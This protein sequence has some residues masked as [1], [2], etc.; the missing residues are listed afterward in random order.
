MVLAVWGWLKAAAT[1]IPTRTGAFP[2]ALAGALEAGRAGAAT[3]RFAPW[4]PAPMSVGI[5][6]VV[7]L[8][9]LVV[10]GCTAIVVVGAGHAAC[11]T[12]GTVGVACGGAID[13]QLSALETS[14]AWV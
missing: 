2:T 6:W 13:R 4:G 9:V 12:C 11:V 1:G 3:D 10:L 14:E 5:R 7:V 8:V